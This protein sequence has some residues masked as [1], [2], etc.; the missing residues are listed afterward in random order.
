[1]DFEASSLGD[2][3]G[4]RRLAFDAAL[5]I[6]DASAE[7]GRLL[8]RGVESCRERGAS[9]AEALLPARSSKADFSCLWPSNDEAKL[10]ILLM[11]PPCAV[12]KVLMVPADAGRG[13]ISGA[14]IKVTLDFRGASSVELFRDSKSDERSGVE[15]EVDSEMGVS[16]SAGGIKYEL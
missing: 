14:S 13:I 7:F 12:V 2:K 6:R 8:L 11:L 1:L 3:G 9:D 10:A 15:T 16:K 4:N 5:R